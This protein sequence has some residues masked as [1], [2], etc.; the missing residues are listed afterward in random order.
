[1]KEKNRQP[2][3]VVVTRKTRME[4]LRQRWST[5]GQMHYMFRQN[6]AYAAMQGG[7]LE[8]AA[9]LSSG[10]DEDILDFED[11]FETYQNAVGELQSELNLGY[12]V[13]VIDREYL[14]TVGFDM[15][16]VVVVIGQD[17]L[18]ANTAKYVGDVPIVAVNPDP[19]RFDGVLLPW[20]LPQVRQVVQRVIKGTY[21]TRD[22]TLA[23]V[24]LQD[25]QRL[26][27]FNDFYIGASSHVSS[28]YELTVGGMTEEQSSSG[29]LVSTGAGS[30]GWISSVLNM[31]RGVCRYLQSDVRPD[32]S[33]QMDWD[34]RRL[35]WVVREPFRS[36]T[37]GV[38]LVCGELRAG[39]ELLIESRMDSGGVIFSD[40][41]E[42]DFLEFNGG[43]IARVGVASQ[44][45]RLVVD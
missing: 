39:E 7:D 37:T 27:A 10:E 13:Q 40:G 9:M 36:R 3:I 26:L 5:R 29:I 12:P 28:R 2:R 45:A 23:E 25:D 6:K 38:D 32:K 41:V 8:A 14:P 4:N 43:A 42:S 34:E 17:G 19:G 44:Q 33:L 15:C 18:V 22:I 30:T 16:S 24:Q 11:E 31:T 21:R 35:L 20:Q 1:M